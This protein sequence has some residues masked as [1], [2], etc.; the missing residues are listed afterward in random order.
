MRFK[1]AGRYTNG[2]ESV[3]IHGVTFDGTTPTTVDDE[4]V[5]AKLK[6]HPEVEIV[7]GRPPKVDDVE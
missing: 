5:I 2:N 6:T 7:T 4:G 3:R 1:F